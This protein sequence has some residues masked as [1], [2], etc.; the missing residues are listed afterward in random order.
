[1]RV[2]LRWKY[3]NAAYIVRELEA[4][5]LEQA[6]SMGAGAKDVLV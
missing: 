6:T 3:A 1:M 5:P 4:V 2:T